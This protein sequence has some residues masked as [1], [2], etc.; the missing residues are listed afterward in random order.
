MLQKLGFPNQFGDPKPIARPVAG[1]SV[2]EIPFVNPLTFCPPTH[3]LLRDSQ[4]FAFG[5]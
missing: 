4:P 3:I 1:Y 5:S 2:L